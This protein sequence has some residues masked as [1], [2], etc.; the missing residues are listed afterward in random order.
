MKKTICALLVLSVLLSLFACGNREDTT[1]T[2]ET[3]EESYVPVD[4]SGIPAPLTING[5]DVPYALYRYYFGA[6]KY[7]YDSDDDSFWEDNDYTEQIRDEVLRYIRRNYA[8]EECAAQ[9]DVQLTESEKRQVEQTIMSDRLQY[10]ND[11]DFYRALD[12]NYLTEDIYRYLEEQASLEDKLLQYLI[13]E[14]SGPKISAEPSLV[15]RY[16]DNYVIRCDHILILNDEGDDRNENETLIK[17]IYEK[18]LSGADFEELKEKYSEDDQTN[19]N[20]VGYY[21]AE[22]DISQILSDAAFA[23]DIGQISEIIYAP[24]GYHIVKR[25]EKDDDYIKDNLGTSFVSFYQSHMLG[26]MMKKIIDKQEIIYDGSYYTYT[27]LS[28]K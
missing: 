24:Y 5:K 21:I 15:Q 28:V 17:E 8:L 11:A 14:E 7:R 23:L 1:Q 6:V 25:L 10:E 9:Y 18:L 26:E 2:D 22:G 12:S 20:D 3:A 13:S 16:I 19:Y 27:P 4:I